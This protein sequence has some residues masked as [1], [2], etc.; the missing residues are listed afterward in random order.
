MIFNCS[1]LQ[2][3]WP[4]GTCEKVFVNKEKLRMH[5]RTHE[6]KPTVSIEMI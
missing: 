3:P 4:C 6:A 2:G 1:T 5:R